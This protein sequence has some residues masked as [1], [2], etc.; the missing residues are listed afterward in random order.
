MF[1]PLLRQLLRRAVYV[2]KRLTDVSESIMETKRAG[3]HV[4]T[5]GQVKPEYDTYLSIKDYPHFTSYVKA[6]YDD[7]VEE[8]ANK[9]LGKC[10]DEL[11]CTQLILWE[12]KSKG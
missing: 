9:C 10:M 4:R 12:K 11:I 5:A 2:I 7:V 8:T 6:L 1:N 3:K